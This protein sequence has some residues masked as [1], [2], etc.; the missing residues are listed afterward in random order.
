MIC[1]RCGGFKIVDH[2][3][4]ALKC[5]GYRCINC[6]AITDIQ[7]LLP[8]MKLRSAGNGGRIRP[9]TR[10]VESRFVN[11]GGGPANEVER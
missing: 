7:I 6:G 4:G 1:T 11:V 10:P 3:Y 8:A 5:D 2:F 9:T